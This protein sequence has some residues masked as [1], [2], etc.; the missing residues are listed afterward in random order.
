MSDF[1]K[2]F[3][4]P[5]LD[6]T[7]EFLN[8]HLYDGRIWDRK[9]EP[10]SNIYKNNKALSAG[11]EK[12]REQVENYAFEMYI[13]QSTELLPEWEESVGLPDECL[14]ISG[15]LEERRNAVIQ[16]LSK[17]AIVTLQE[18]QEYVSEIF[19]QVIIRLSPG[20][21][22]LSYPLSYPFSYWGGGNF[23]KFVLVVEY[24]KPLGAGYPAAYPFP[25]SRGVDEQKIECVLNKIIPADV[26]LF[27]K[28]IQPPPEAVS[29]LL[30]EEGFFLLTESGG[31]III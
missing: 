29:Y 21:D 2:F 3:K 14:G 4:A 8:R 6:K 16:R 13:P 26:V 25:Y 15:S 9:N 19:P 22:H 5:G 1:D 18:L 28:A 12:I 27:L 17:I 31:R 11:F 20:Q 24:I 7:T 10:D 30:T 23:R